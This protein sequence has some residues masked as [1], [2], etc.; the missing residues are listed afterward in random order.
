MRYDLNIELRNLVNVYTIQMWEQLYNTL[1]AK[2]ARAD[3]LD[4]VA[5]VILNLKDIRLILEHQ[6]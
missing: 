3:L 1:D 6:V 2:G 5:E 4:D